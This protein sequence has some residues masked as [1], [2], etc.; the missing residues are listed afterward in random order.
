M[1][2]LIGIGAERAFGRLSLAG[3]DRDLARRV[4]NRLAPD[5]GHLV[6][7]HQKADTV[8]E[9]LRH[10]ARSL[11]DGSGIVADV[12][13]REAVVLRV[14]HV[15]EDLG[16]AQQRLGRDA[17]PVETDTAEIISFDDR[18]LEPELC[19][20]DRGDIAAGPRA[21]IDD[22]ERIWHLHLH[23]SPCALPTEAVR[24][25]RSISVERSDRVLHRPDWTILGR[26]ESFMA[27]SL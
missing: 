14:L 13:G 5:D 8:I 26:L 27:C 21:D 9:P 17:A 16:R 22:V 24:Y 11:D 1:L 3:L 18:R 12:L 6:L 23:D 7:P 15:V 2:R 10:H 25:R 4:D 20:A 19:R